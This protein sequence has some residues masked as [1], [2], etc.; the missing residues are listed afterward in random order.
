SCVILRW[1]IRRTTAGEE[2]QMKRPDEPKRGVQ[3]RPFRIAY[4]VTHPIQYQAPLLRYLNAQPD[5]EITVFFQTDISL[6]SYHD[7]GFGRR[8]QWDVPFL[9]GYRSEVLPALGRRDS[10]EG[11]RPFN[12]GIARRLKEGQFDLLWV[13]GYAR[14]FNWA[15]MAAA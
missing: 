10:I 11:G 14:W 1:G 13:H 7:T 12:Y 15:A 9:E 4:L 5:I 8:I 3:A 2:G 6:Q